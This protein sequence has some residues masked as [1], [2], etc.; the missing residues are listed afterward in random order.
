MDRNYCGIRWGL[1]S[2]YDHTTSVIGLGL[3]SKREKA[4]HDMVINFL[5]NN[6][7]PFYYSNNYLAQ[8][9]DA[10]VRIIKYWVKH[11]KE[12]NLINISYEQ[13]L[14]RF[15]YLP[16][17]K[18]QKPRRDSLSP[19]RKIDKRKKS[20]QK[21][22]SNIKFQKVLIREKKTKSIPVE[23]LFKVYT[24]KPQKVT[25]VNNNSWWITRK[26][27]PKNPIIFTPVALDVQENTLLYNINNIYNTGNE[28][29]LRDF[30]VQKKRNKERQQNSDYVKRNNDFYDLDALEEETKRELTQERQTIFNGKGIGS[31]QGFVSL[32]SLLGSSRRRKAKIPLNFARRDVIIPCMPLST[33]KLSDGS[34]GSTSRQNSPFPFPSCTKAQNLLSPFGEK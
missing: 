28:K 2:F 5:K 18:F 22:L 7:R 12:L 6:D 13:G 34:G 31:T 10:S 3:K 32:G 33:E 4:F 9:M 11:L 8:R 1:C 17:T 26:V 27:Y 23:K 14:R 29:N 20:Y 21:H 24:L 15:I 25:D 16:G 19:H 30:W